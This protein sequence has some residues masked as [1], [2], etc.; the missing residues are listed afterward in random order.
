MALVLLGAPAADGG[1]RPPRRGSTS[2]A[3]SCRA[4]ATRRR[5]TWTRPS[6]ELFALADEEIV[7]NLATGGPFASPDFIQERLE[8]FMS[9]WGGAS[10]RVHR[11][12]SGACADIAD[13]RRVRRA[14]SRAVGLRARVRAPPRRDDRAARRDRARRHARAP[15]LAGGARRRAA[16]RRDV[17]R[18]GVG[19]RRAP[20]ARRAVAR[21]AATASSGCGRRPRRFPMDC[22]RR[23]SRSRTERS[24]SATSSLSRL[25]AG[26]RPP[27][28]ARRTSIGRM[29]G[30]PGL[31]LSRR[32]VVNGWH[33]DLQPRSVG[34]S[35][36]WLGR[37]A[38][39]ARAGARS[40][41]GGALAAR[42]R[43]RAGVRRGRSGLAD[44]RDGGG[45]ARKRATP[46]CRGR[47]RGVGRAT[48]GG[49]SL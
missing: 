6:R 28:G 14:G 48:G 2:C 13:G 27:D 46:S 30:A 8:A 37:R 19:S 12:A 39:R 18:R 10:F 34:F 38:G 44:D 40:R 22:P 17:V 41:A 26:L 23:R 11:L 29:R 31:V 3:R 47:S 35:T 4:R 7:E 45:D 43:P 20:A 16:V 32:N 36:R 49:W 33:R 21:A 5:P 1:D 9:A 42:A 24:R 25:E 15:P